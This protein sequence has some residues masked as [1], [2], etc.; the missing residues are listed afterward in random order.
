MTPAQPSPRPD[1]EI[2]S[3]ETILHGRKFDFEQLTLRTAEG[4]SLTR[5]VVRH[6][7]AVVVLAV[8]DEGQVV[9]V[10]NLRHAIGARLLELCAGTLEVG[11][12]P[13][14]CAHREL[15]EETG[16]EAATIRPLGR[17][18]TTPGLTDELM[19]AFVA[20][21]L[22]EV[23]ARPEADEW[24]EVVRCSPS[25][26]LEMIDRGELTDAKSMLV[27]LWALRAGMLTA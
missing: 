5:Q 1:P 12:E 19:H 4:Q 14:L 9:F 7:G 11:E 15:I 26:A 3:R 24:L 2:V 6:P 18:Y 22:R 25:E 10:R 21:G 17:F 23:G 27:L 16:Y 20:T 13:E 8:T